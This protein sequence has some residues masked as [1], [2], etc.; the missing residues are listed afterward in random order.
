[1]QSYEFSR[2]I[3]GVVACHSEKS[4]G[5]VGSVPDGDNIVSEFELQSR[6][7]FPFRAYIPGKGINSLI[8]LAMG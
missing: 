1:M 7:Y 8:P 5:I 2:V 6:N 3:I 4:C